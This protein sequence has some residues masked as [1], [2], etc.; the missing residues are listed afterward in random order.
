MYVR[1]YVGLG[2]IKLNNSCLGYRTI[3]L[4][5]ELVLQ[6]LQFPTRYSD[7]GWTSQK[8]LSGTVRGECDKKELISTG[9]K[10][11]LEIKR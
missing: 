5:V 4:S 11:R 9:R 6:T 7:D 3:V 10:I 8:G 2:E 1:N